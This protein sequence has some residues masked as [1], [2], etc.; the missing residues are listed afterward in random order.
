MSEQP[1]VNSD[2]QSQSSE[3]TSEPYAVDNL[4]AQIDAHA[5]SVSMAVGDQAVADPPMSRRDFLGLGT[6]TSEVTS[7]FWWS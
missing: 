4:Y 5:A 6:S 1:Q 2:Q 3:S 7:K